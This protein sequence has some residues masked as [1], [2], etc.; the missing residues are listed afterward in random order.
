MLTV[1]QRFGVDTLQT[2]QKASDPEAGT[3]EVKESKIISFTINHHHLSPDHPT[4][5]RL[6]HPNLM[7]RD[8]TVTIQYC[9]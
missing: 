4:P 3:A 8:L 2:T 6:I 1:S 9:V 5:F 7:R